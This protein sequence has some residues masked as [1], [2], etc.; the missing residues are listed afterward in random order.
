MAKPISA[1]SKR[2]SFVLAGIPIMDYDNPQY[3]G[4]LDSLTPYNHQIN[5]GF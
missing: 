4:L 5:Q 3:T 1:F 2:H